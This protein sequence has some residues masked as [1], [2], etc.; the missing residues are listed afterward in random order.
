LR[1]RCHAGFESRQRIG[2]HR[3]RQQQ[4]RRV[5]VTEDRRLVAVVTRTRSTPTPYA[6]PKGPRRCETGAS[7]HPHVRPAL[8]PPTLPAVPARCSQRCTSRTRWS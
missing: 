5:I 4:R 6:T 2:G 1:I 3:Q 7:D 8:W